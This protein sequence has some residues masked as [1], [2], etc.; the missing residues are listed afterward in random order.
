LADP[1]APALRPA[2]EAALDELVQRHG[3]GY[4]RRDQVVLEQELALPLLAQRD[5]GD[6][7]DADRVEVAGAA[8]LVAP[9]AAADPL[10]HLRAPAGDEEML[11]VDRAAREVGA[12]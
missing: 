4:G 12:V 9:L 7:G 10:A 2:R 3:V 11:D 8:A 1:R 5:R 6:R